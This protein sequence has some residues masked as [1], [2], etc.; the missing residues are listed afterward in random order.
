VESSIIAPRDSV[1]PGVR[2]TFPPGKNQHTSYPFGLH[3]KF[4]LL[5]NYFSEGE[6]FF[7]RSN[8]CRQR[9]PSPEP[10]LCKSCDELDRRDDF[11]DGI[12]ERITNGINEN[13]LLMFFPFG[14]LIRRVR[15]KN[16]QLRVMRLID[17]RKIKQEAD[18][19]LGA[20]NDVD[21]DGSLEYFD[22][23]RVPRL[24]PHLRITMSTRSRT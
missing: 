21:S 5:W 4:S 24:G 3:A 19:A 11:L 6:H 16:D 1:C 13:T 9:V 2:L 12:R 20:W 23:E 17:V 8:R 14:G 10:R 18:D 15:K 22:E 7:L